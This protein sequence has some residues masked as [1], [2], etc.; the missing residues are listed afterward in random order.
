MLAFHPASWATTPEPLWVKVAFHNCVIDWPF[1]N[2][3]A[4]V[5]P[6]TTGPRLVIVTFAWKPV[7]HWFTML[8]VTLQ[9][10]AVLPTIT[11]T[12]A[13]VAVAPLLLAA[14]AVSE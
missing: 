13:E 6:L 10:A 5:H 12:G 7:F 3:Q 1:G 11:V 8:Y 4:N 2:D 14:F 9:A